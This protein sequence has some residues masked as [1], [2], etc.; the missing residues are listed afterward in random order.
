MN[1]WFKIAIAATLFLLV[2][3]ATFFVFYDQNNRLINTVISSYEIKDN[4]IICKQTSS[5][6]SYMQR[7]WFIMKLNEREI[8]MDT[9][10]VICKTLYPIHLLV[11][12]VDKR[13]NDVLNEDVRVPLDKVSD[14]SEL[15]TSI[16]VNELQLN[17]IVQNVV[18]NRINETS[19]LLR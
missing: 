14:I 17:M 9:F 5:I 11:M 2:Y 4:I 16:S 12:A 18:E 19:Y 6:D 3:T 1:K 7:E 13:K 10:N 8:G 15:S